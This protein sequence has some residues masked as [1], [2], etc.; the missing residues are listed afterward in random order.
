[1]I[2]NLKTIKIALLGFSIC[3]AIASCQKD[4]AEEITLDN[5]IQQA[6]SGAKKDLKNAAE[7]KLKEALLSKQMFEEY[8]ST[9]L[10]RKFSSGISAAVEPTECGPT[11]LDFRINYY[12]SQF[13]PL[14]FELFDLYST[15]NSLSTYLD[16]SRQFFGKKGEYTKLVSKHR[17]ALERF[18]RLKGITVR[19]MHNCTLNDRDK[20]AEVYIVFAGVPEELAYLYADEIIAINKQS[21]VF[22][23]TPL[24]SFNAF[25]STDKLVV[26]GD[27]LVQILGETGIRNDVTVTGAFSH[28]WGHQVQFKYLLEWYG[29]NPGDPIYFDPE[30]S[31]KF[32]TEADYF[33]G[34]YLT[35]T[36]GGRYYWSDAAEFFTLFYS[37][38]DCA[39]E[40]I[41]HHGTPNQRLAAVR[42]GWILS[43]VTSLKGIVLS[44]N[45]LHFIYSLAF[46]EIIIGNNN[47]ALRSKA[48]AALKSSKQAAI[49]KEVLKYEKELKSI[50][51]G[52]LTKEEIK[53]LK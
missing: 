16:E 40:S 46:D 43:N 22:T 21:P 51:N 5:K 53:N 49:Y 15:I 25:A 20:I 52:E 45:D 27:G 32:E 39:F 18:W 42:L 31:R 12:I 23:E 28:E 29:I 35:H 10:K 13:G 26:I 50:A 48:T 6:P 2:M 41:S 47:L 30:V 14:E 24:L 7:L 3:F 8:Y 17:Q 38:G 9:L 1:M 37:L 4:A 36:K 33:A 34:Y 44:A 11:P 19:G